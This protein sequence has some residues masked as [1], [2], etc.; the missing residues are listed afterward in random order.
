MRIS[1]W[2][3]D[4]C[5]SDLTS[6]ATSAAAPTGGPDR[7]RVSHRASLVSSMNSPIASSSGAVGKHQA[8]HQLDPAVDQHEQKQLEMQRDSGRKQHHHANRQQ[9]FGNHPD[10]LPT[11]KKN[12][13]EKQ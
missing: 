1:D 5:S 8:V 13:T 2:S 11:P 12:K 3:S 10:E 7:T 9:D 4:V 6:R